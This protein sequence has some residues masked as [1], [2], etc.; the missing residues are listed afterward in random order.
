MIWWENLKI[1][2]LESARALWEESHPK[3]VPTIGGETPTLNAH[4]S[5][6]NATGPQADGIIDAAG[7]AP[8]P[9]KP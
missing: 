3:L 1:K 4:G 5:A 9:A 6:G 8:L 7:S 2:P